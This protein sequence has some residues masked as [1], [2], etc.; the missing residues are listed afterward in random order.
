MPWR[1][2]LA[3]VT[4]EVDESLLLR[5]EYLIE[6]NRVLRRQVKRLRLN[7]TERR[8]LAE[9][10]MQ[11]GKLMAD[12][13]TIVKPETLLKWHRELIARK[14]NGSEQQKHFGRPRITAEISD[15]VVSMAKKIRLGATIEYAEL[16]ATSGSGSAIRASGIS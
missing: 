11:L 12:T 1:K 8:T 16:C 6:E 9:K 10:A 14:Y 15:L 3:Y 13:V 4:G 7:D 5:I 2:I